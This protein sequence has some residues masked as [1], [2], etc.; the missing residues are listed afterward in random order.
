MNTVKL[1]ISGARPLTLPLSLVAVALGVA[2][3]VFLTP[4][5][6]TLSLAL[7]VLCFAVAF[8]LQIGVNY[9]N[10]YSDGIRGT[11]DRSV[12][13]GPVRLVGWGL[14]APKTVLRMALVA[15]ALAAVSGL[16]IVLLSGYW[17]LL[18]VGAA[19]LLAAWFYTGGKRPYGYAPFG[20]LAVLLFF[21][22]VPVVAT[23]YVLT[24]TVSV[25]VWLAGLSAGIF[26]A[27]VLLTNNIRDREKDVLHSKR[28][29]SVVIGA[30][31]SRVLYMILLLAPFGLLAYFAAK[32]PAALLVYAILPIIA[33]PTLTN[34]LSA[35]TTLEFVASLKQ[36]LFTAAIFE[37]S[38]ALAITYL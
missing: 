33:V 24:G 27:A 30:P 8:F 36:T 34:F 18:A 25:E 12:R 19:C 6:E 22:I 14:A 17:W 1:W 11:D 16:G 9:A 2:C 31:A 26:A 38:L 20:E 7:I 21:G 15:F 29:L 4:E 23:A 32:H 28:T 10:D 13:R 37:L 5:G 35:R 3:A